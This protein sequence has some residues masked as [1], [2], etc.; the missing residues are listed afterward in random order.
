MNSES[1]ML[2][3]ARTA[4]MVAGSV[5]SRTCSRGWPFLMALN[6]CFLSTSAKTRAAHSQHHVGVRAAV[7]R[8]LAELGGVLEHLL[9]DVQPTEA[10]ADLLALGRVGAPQRG[11]FGP[12]RRRSVLCELSDIRADALSGLRLPSGAST[13]YQLALRR[14]KRGAST[15]ERML[16]IR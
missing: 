12:R 9:G 1:W 4:R 11:V 15:W 14:A 10:V 8:Q 5:V 16:P 3:L 7:H 13:T 6:V 2:I